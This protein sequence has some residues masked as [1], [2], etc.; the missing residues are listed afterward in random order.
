M[1]E[2]NIILEKKLAEF[3]HLFQEGVL[4][5]EKD[6]ERL[7]FLLGEFQ[8]IRSELGKHPSGGY[9]TDIFLGV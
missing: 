6:I 3:D 8:A 1:E 9:T 4:I 5:P 7:D 2:I